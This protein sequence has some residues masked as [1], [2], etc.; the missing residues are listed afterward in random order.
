MAA[1]PAGV[2]PRNLNVWQ[3][4]KKPNVLIKFSNLTFI[5]FYLKHIGIELAFEIN[6]PTRFS[7]ILSYLF[8]LQMLKGQHFSGALPPKRLP[9]LHHE[10]FCSKVDISE[11]AR[12]NPRPEIKKRLSLKPQGINRNRISVSSS[13]R[14]CYF[15][16]SQ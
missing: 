16:F 5:K 10:L 13:L 6:Q 3:T 9:G 15:L 2:Y 1:V 12:I 11:T 14:Y 8:V 4:A 7:S